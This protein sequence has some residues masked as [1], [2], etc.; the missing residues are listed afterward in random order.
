MA[1]R[2]VKTLSASN[3][4]IILVSADRTNG[5]AYATVLP[6]SVICNVCIV[7]KRLTARLTE[8][9]YEERNRKWPK[10]ESNGHV[11]DAVT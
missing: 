4:P 10:R 11:T 8:K 6:L 3:S 5:C 2:I 7:A 9:L 1:K